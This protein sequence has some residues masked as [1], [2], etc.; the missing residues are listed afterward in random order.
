MNMQK[1]E[2]SQSDDQETP[3]KRYLRENCLNWPVR[4]T[5]DSYSAPINSAI[6]R[7]IH[8][9]KR[10]EVVVNRSIKSYTDLKSHVEGLVSELN[11]ESRRR[12]SDLKSQLN[13]LVLSFQCL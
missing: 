13:R 9:L 2:T 1:S 12:K 4:L 6:E 5:Q 11:G 7:H 8:L 3:A 10:N